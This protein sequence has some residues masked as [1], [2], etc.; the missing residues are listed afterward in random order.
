L[1]GALAPRCKVGVCN[2]SVHTLAPLCKPSR[3]VST[4]GSHES[5]AGAPA[6]NSKALAKAADLRH[7]TFDICRT[8][9]SKL[10]LVPHDT[11]WPPTC[12]LVASSTTLSASRLVQKSA[13][14]RHWQE[15]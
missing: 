6:L 15:L 11:G 3:I 13:A 2:V 9:N 12:P 1:A 10:W 4:P 5:T 14:L 8:F 7:L